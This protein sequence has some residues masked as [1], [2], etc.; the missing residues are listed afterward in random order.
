MHYESFYRYEYLNRFRCKSCLNIGHAVIPWTDAVTILNIPHSS[1]DKR[2]AI[3][4]WGTKITFFK[5]T[6]GVTTCNIVRTLY[7]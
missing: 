5:K 3:L 7:W 2:R 1:G 4:Q 6:I